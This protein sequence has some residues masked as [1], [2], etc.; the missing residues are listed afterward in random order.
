MKEKNS[1]KHESEKIAIDYLKNRQY[2][3]L[4]HNFLIQTEK[5]KVE[6][7][8]IAFHQM[9]KRLH[10]VEVKRWKKNFFIHP[11][12]REN[13]KRKELLYE[14]Y[15]VFLKM[16]RQNL[17]MYQDLNEFK[18]FI[19]FLKEMSVWDVGVSFDLIWIQ[20]RE[21]KHYKNIFF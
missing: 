8:I 9:E 11:L 6:I 17:E 2:D 13:S 20:D 12:L 3:V 19:N 14:A 16:V 1:F 5:R 15:K 18:N 21:I 10:F 7:D 4:K